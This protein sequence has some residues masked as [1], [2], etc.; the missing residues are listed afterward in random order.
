MCTLVICR[1]PG[2]DWPLI[3]AAN[4][5]EMLDRSW[6]PPGRHWPDRAHVVAGIDHLAGGSWLGLNDDGIVAGVLNRVGALGPAAGVRSRGELVLEAL[7]HAEARVAAAALAHIDPAAY[8]PFN[9]VV[10]DAA[11]AFWLCARAGAS[12][13]EAAPLA[14]GVSMLTAYDLDDPASPRTALYLPRFRAAQAPDPEA[15]SWSDWE[16]LLASR[17]H[18][19][20][21]GPDGA[22][23]VVT[24][25]GFGTVSASLLALPRHGR[26]GVAPH[27]R[28]AAGAPGEAPFEAVSL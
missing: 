21:V 16:A 11:E 13:V 5:D 8:R 3:L 4:R 25:I 17:V 12:K 14:S 18:D 24:G 23:K 7:D 15:G 10:A 27:W 22:M 28:F 9:L 26:S 20:E 1:R 19:A 2:H 6:S